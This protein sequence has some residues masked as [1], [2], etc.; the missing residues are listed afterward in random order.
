MMQL[1]I[2][3]FDVSISFANPY[4]VLVSKSRLKPALDITDNDSPGSFHDKA[5]TLQFAD[6]ILI[7]NV[8]PIDNIMALGAS[9]EKIL[10][11]NG[12]KEEVYLADFSPSREAIAEIPFDSYV[13]LRPE[14][15]FA[16]YV[17]CKSIITREIARELSQCNYKIVYLPRNS[18]EQ[19]L[20]DGLD[21]IY[22]PQRPLDGRNLVWFSSCVLTGSG[23]L[24]REA[25]LMGIP[26]V[27][28]YPGKLISVDQKLVDEGKIFHS[29][30]PEDIKSY[31]K[32]SVRVN[33]SLAQL[34][35]KWIAAKTNCLRQV[36]YALLRMTNG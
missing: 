7:P 27:S 15:S 34:R 33:Q 17:Q 4:A 12:Y 10:V 24:A 23:T 20:V 11:F 1:Y 29:R 36:N 14:A 28:F 9:K 25:A 26:A 2:P 6:Y 13:V 32:K 8:I 31:V 18:E 30:N 35:G 3:R 5:V 16:H 22:I 21:N 19:R